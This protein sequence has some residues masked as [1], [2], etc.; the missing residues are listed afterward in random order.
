MSGNLF[1]I[2]KK[3]LCFYIWIVGDIIWFT[4]DVKN[5]AYGRAFLDLIQLGFAIF[6]IYEWQIKSK[7]IQTSEQNKN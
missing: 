1:N 5:G 7:K 4:L 2:K 3:V 6:G